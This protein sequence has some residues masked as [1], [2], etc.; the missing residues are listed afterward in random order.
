MAITGQQWMP[1][2]CSS[3][4]DD[5]ACP[6]RW[7]IVSCLPVSIVAS[8]NRVSRKELFI[9]VVMVKLTCPTVRTW[10]SIDMQVSCR[11]LIFHWI[12]GS[13][14][15]ARITHLI[16][17]NIATWS[18][19]YDSYKLF[20]W[21]RGLQLFTATCLGI[22]EVRFQ[23][24]SLFI[25]NLSV[26]T[27]GVVCQSQQMYMGVGGDGEWS[28]KI[29]LGRARV[30]GNLH[31]KGRTDEQEMKRERSAKWALCLIN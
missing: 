19:C 1:L 18:S 11:P 7:L 12:P 9:L 10:V 5:R 27:A 17:T 24:R 20:R 8:L 13:L 25:L 22:K 2:A 14:W 6:V 3:S 4:K 29:N 31:L 15:F 30:Q 23:C 26:H 28:F 16:A 21:A